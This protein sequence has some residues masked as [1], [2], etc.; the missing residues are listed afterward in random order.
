MQTLRSTIASGM[1]QDHKKTAARRRT[2]RA[3]RPA[4]G[5]R[6][7][8]RRPRGPG[9]ARRA[10][11]PRSSRR[12][13]GRDDRETYFVRLGPCSWPLSL[14][15]VNEGY[16]TRAGRGW[17]GGPRPTCASV[18]AGTLQE[19]RS[20]RNAHGKPI[21]RHDAVGRPATTPRSRRP[22]PVRLPTVAVLLDRLA[23]GAAQQHQLLNNLRHRAELCR[24]EIDAVVD[25]VC[26]AD[27]RG[28]QGVEVD[29]LVAVGAGS[30]GVALPAPRFR[31]AGR[32]RRW[33][34]AP[35]AGSS[36]RRSR[37]SSSPSASTPGGGSSSGS[38]RPT[39]WPRVRIYRDGPNVDDQQRH[40]IEQPFTTTRQSMLGLAWR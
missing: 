19:A 16:R 31:V 4:R 12:A 35:T 5:S 36:I 21:G 9:T 23:P 40:W 1:S 24:F 8:P 25:L 39:A 13:G 20:P 28:P 32:S 30:G 18:P 17:Q 14:W 26:P 22:A 15:R 3:R 10:A 34:S 29:R 7:T 11:S 37:S 2:A 33:P 6:R 38:N 27:G